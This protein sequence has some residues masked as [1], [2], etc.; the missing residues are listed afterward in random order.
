M[1]IKVQQSVQE[2]G[3]HRKPGRIGPEQDSAQK[4]PGSQSPGSEDRV[5]SS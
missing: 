5:D 1:A 2:S 3:M 4:G